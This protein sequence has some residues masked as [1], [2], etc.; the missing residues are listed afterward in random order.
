[1]LTV[2]LKSK[3]RERALAVQ[4]F[5]HAIPALPLL[6][7]GLQAIQAGEHGLAFA[8]ALFEI[9][10]SVMLLGT[11]VREIRTLRRPRPHAAHAH[12]GVD[13][14][15]IFAASVLVAEVLE[16]YHVTHHIRR[17]TVLTA[18]VTLALGLF[19]GRITRFSE[20][21]RVLRLEDDGVHI[22]GKFFQSFRARWE[23]ITSIEIEERQV[24]KWLVAAGLAAGAF[25]LNRETGRLL[26]PIVVFWLLSYF[27]RPQS[28]H[29]VMPCA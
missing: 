15:H 23:D 22:G 27:R 20:G 10:T 19:H 28:R 12:H 25:S 24:R 14:V 17:P 29:C 21:R 9:G 18:A 4:K 3:R 11:V 8:L 5:Q 13:W 2:P 7:A 16:H 6:F 26:Y 1:M